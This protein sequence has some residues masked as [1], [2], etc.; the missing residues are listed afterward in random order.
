MRRPLLPCRRNGL[1]PMQ[2]AA[3][4]STAAIGFPDPSIAGDC[5]R[6]MFG[7]KDGWADNTSR[8]YCSRTGPGSPDSARSLRFRNRR[9]T[10]S[11]RFMPMTPL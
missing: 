11:T 1:S 9:G 7:G 3:A 5:F 4:S 6:G 10:S 2:G 8:E